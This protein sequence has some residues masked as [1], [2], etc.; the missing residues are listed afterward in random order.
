MSG[1]YVSDEDVWVERGAVPWRDARRNASETADFASWGDDRLVYLGIDLRV[2]V[3]DEN[4]AP[5]QS[6]Y[7]ADARGEAPPCGCCRV[8][9]A[10]HFRWEER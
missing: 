10:Y 2:L 5:C 6:A 9:Y 8:I 1:P 3:C 4:E 7:E